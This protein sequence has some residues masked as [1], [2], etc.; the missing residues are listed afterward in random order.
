MNLRHCVYRIHQSIVID[1]SIVVI[2]NSNSNR[3][4]EPVKV[5]SDRR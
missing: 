1:V 5:R 3:V 2:T 4:P